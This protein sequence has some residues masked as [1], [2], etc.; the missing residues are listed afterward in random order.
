MRNGS[1]SA[2]DAG[3]ERLSSNPIQD[4]RVSQRAGRSDL[5]LAKLNATP[6]GCQ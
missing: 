3:G 5:R 4:M 2:T 1:A 6:G